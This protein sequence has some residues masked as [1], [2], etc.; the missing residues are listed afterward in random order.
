MGNRHVP[1]PAQIVLALLAA[2]V[3][4]SPARAE[5]KPAA[6]K[7]PA[8]QGSLPDV[9]IQ[10]EENQSVKRDK[11]ALSLN[12]KEEEPLESMLKT[13]QEIRLRLPSEV[14]R[15]TPS[16]S[17]ASDSPYVAAPSS[18]LIYLL[19]KGEPAK[20]FSPA[21][22]LA[23]VYKERDGKK[24]AAKAGW[25]LVIADA[26]GGVFR[27]FSGAGLPPERLV[28]DGKGD[29][30]RW[31]KVGQVYT[32]VL[33]YKDAEGRAHTAMGRSFSL[34]GLAIQKPDGFAI[35]LDPQA[36]FEPD[37]ATLRPSE[38][39]LRLLREAA[40]II[41]RYHPGLT[42]DV[43]AYVS[44]GEAGAAEQGARACAAELSRLLALGPKA[45]ASRGSAGTAD[46]DRRVEVH[47]LNR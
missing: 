2:A 33:T 38:R 23:E 45:I 11:P 18:N 6:P 30:G 36:V 31:L 1:L 5:D 19:W 16:V 32:S 43:S 34:Q 14:A 37:A 22:E 13:E 41:Q 8:A 29:D 15:S 39:G 40:Q 9:L 3:L 35:D 25:E 42:L 44:R 7:E 27:R 24:A 17:G 20:V 47:V 21:K 46:L 4:S 28:F 10:A 26:A 12:L